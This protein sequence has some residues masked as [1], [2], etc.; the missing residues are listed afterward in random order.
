MGPLFLRIPPELAAELV[1]QV[2]AALEKAKARI[3]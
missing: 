2:Q 1:E 3:G